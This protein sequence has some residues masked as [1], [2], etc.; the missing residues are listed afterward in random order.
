MVKGLFA[1]C[2]L[3]AIFAGSVLQISD[4]PDDPANYVFGAVMVVVVVLFVLEIV[5]NS[6]TDPFY[7]CSFFCWMDILGTASM[8][9]EISYL[10]G[11]TGASMTQPT[12][13]PVLLR[14]AR[15]AKTA[16]RAGRFLKIT[17]VLEIIVTRRAK[18]RRDRDTAQQLS[19]K[20]TLAL[21]TKVSLLTILLVI[22]V[23]VFKIGQYPEE[24]L[25]MRGWGRRLEEGYRDAFAALQAD[26]ESRETSEFQEVVQDMMAFY[27]SVSYFP[28]LLEGYQEDVL[29]GNRSASIL[30]PGLFAQYETPVRRQ[31]IRRQ[32]VSECLLQREDCSGERHAAVLFNFRGS[33]RVEAGME[34][35][36]SCFVIV[37]MAVMTSDLNQTVD[38]LLVRPL[39]RMLAMVREIASTIIG[40]FP[41]TTKSHG[42]AGDAAPDAG[43]PDEVVLL[44]RAFEKLSTLS[45]IY[46]QEKAVDAKLMEGVCDE[47]KGVIVDLMM[48]EHR[49]RQIVFND[50]QQNMVAQ[51][52]RRAVASMDDSKELG[53]G[54]LPFDKVLIESWGCDLLST[55]AEGRQQI[56]LH[57]FFD[58]SMG[59]YTGV[60]FSQIRLFSGFYEAVMRHYND[61]LPYHNSTHAVD[62]LHAVYR[63]LQMTVAIQW[64]ADV[65]V[66]ALMV[67]ALA[68]DVGHFGR[69]NPFLVEVGH[70]LAL[71]YNDA[72]P[73]ENMHC[74]T[75]FTI[76]ADSAVD[77]F[78][79]L[80]SDG[81]KRARK[82]CVS[83]ILHTDNAQHFDMVKDLARAYE[84]A[85][86]H[87]D[88]QAL[89]GDDLMVPY[90]M[91]V[92]KKDSLLYLELFLHL[93]DVSNPLRPF[94]ICRSWAW[95]V[96]EEFFD[97]G[98]E[99]KRLGV[100]VGMLND[101]DVVNIPGSQHGFI[102]FLVAPLVFATIRIFPHLHPLGYQMAAAL[103]EWRNVWVAEVR[104]DSE[105]LAK[106][107]AEVRKVAVTAEEL[108]MRCIKVNHNASMNSAVSGISGISRRSSRSSRVSH[109]S[110]G[111]V[112]RFRPSVR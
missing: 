35:L 79:N 58:S 110:V 46:L 25:S 40:L 10:Y 37:V 66:Y 48:M 72:S 20:L 22:L 78:K 38:R 54:P 60:R 109:V 67:A 1:V 63:L 57:M 107:D 11:T 14:T 53:V 44:E 93:S 100:P 3:F 7:P 75:L 62:I 96:L 108:R 81:Y 84:V 47:S 74:A 98:D 4:L 27:G 70:A 85:T 52:T 12:V 26:P 15:V 95:R 49:S 101:R 89:N 77:V 43:T 36:V 68:H 18:P 32:V 16:A 55:E 99:E 65:E 105:A 102:N 39:E 88:R 45:T 94:E 86:E 87:C 64:V 76:L 106:K 30:G 97:Q 80:A 112:D 5:L 2:L 6:L 104:P 41:E 17:K 33:N 56:A 8:V 83:T 73:L 111:L 29:V 50:L 24:D 59:G 61:E 51:A 90:R 19:M 21:S 92:L 71:Q 28:F 31:N 23:P 91:D 103:Q 9:F 82:V 13:D 42:D 34:M 69:T